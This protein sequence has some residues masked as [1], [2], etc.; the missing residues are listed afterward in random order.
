GGT[1]SRRAHLERI[2][3]SLARSA[4]DLCA[5]PFSQV[6][7]L[8]DVSAW[9]AARQVDLR[10][11]LIAEDGAHAAAVAGIAR[12]ALSATAPV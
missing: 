10:H 12:C 1:R 4:R 2:P 7:A 6:A 5:M 9:S 8:S 11:A 3:N